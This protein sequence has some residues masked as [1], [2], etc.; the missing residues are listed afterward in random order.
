MICYD[1]LWHTM[2]KNNVTTYTLRN[3]YN[4]SNSTIQ[5]MKKNMPVSTNTLDVLCEILNCRVQDILV[6][7]PNAK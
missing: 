7:I 1:P 4:V 3:K 5:R 6:H 2:E